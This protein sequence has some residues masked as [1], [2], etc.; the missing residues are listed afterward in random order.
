MRQ[1]FDH[2][3]SLQQIEKSTFFY[4]KQGQELNPIV[5]QWH[6]LITKLHQKCDRGRVKRNWLEGLSPKPGFYSLCFFRRCI[7]KG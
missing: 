4:A 6:T 5:H 7:N 3:F 2:K 1:P